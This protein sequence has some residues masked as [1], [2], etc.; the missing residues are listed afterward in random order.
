METVSN[1]NRSKDVISFLKAQHLQI[2]RL[3]EEVIEADGHAR[4]EAFNQL[5]RLLAAH[6]AAEEAV[7][8]PV[9]G[10]IAG[11]TAEVKAR[12]AEENEAKQ[13]IAELSRL[14]VLS[15]QFDADIR[16]LRKSVLAHAKLEETEEFDQL[17]KNLN[18]AEL[19]AMCE[20]VETVEKSAV[21]R[22][23]SS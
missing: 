5:R 14:N 15:G 6:E 21:K 4:G 20:Q 13:A 18:A 8:H 19:S 1:A 17:A 11:G 9:A 12:I 3:F 22:T 23:P 16:K 10:T 2:R 7:V